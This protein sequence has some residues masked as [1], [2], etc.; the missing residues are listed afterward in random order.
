MPHELIY[1][2]YVNDIGIAEDQGLIR[3]E[4]ASLVRRWATRNLDRRIRSKELFMS[5]HKFRFF[6]RNV[7]ISREVG[8]REKYA[9]FRRTMKMAMKGN[10]YRS[11]NVS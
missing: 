7:L 3:H 4:E 2:Q 10:L 6:L 9:L 1:Q 8:I 5:P 11:D